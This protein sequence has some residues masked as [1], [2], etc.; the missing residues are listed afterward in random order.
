VLVSMSRRNRRSWGKRALAHETR[1]RIA[2][3]AELAEE[4]YEPGVISSSAKLPLALV[5]EMLAPRLARNK[6]GGA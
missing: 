6:G 1:S 5:E 3:V 4:G 2:K